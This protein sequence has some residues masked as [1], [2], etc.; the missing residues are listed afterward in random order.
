MTERQAAARPDLSGNLRGMA[1]MFL[2]TMLFA[3]MHACVRQV[4]QD[5]DPLIVA[6]FRNFFG[7]AVILPI[8]LRTGMAPLKTKRLGLLI[9][10]AAI[11]VVAM[12]TFF[13]ALSMTPLADVAAL[14]FT[15][16][17][18]ATL[19][20]M[21]VLGE[22]VHLRRWTAILL[23]F[24]GTFVI[25]RPGF[26]TVSMGELLVLISALAW[27]IA[28]IIIKVLGRTESALMITIYMVLLMA[29]LSLVPAAFV[30][31]WPV[32]LEWLWLIAIGALG[33]FA[34]LTMTQS[35][36]EGETQVVMPLDFFKLIWAAL[37]GYFAFAEV[38]DIFVWL[39]GVMIFASAFYIA[40]RESQLNRQAVKDLA[41][42]T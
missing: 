34:Q 27:S 29:P 14:G 21:I 24:A 6:F 36:K 1:W 8:L 5:L 9:L 42:P 13:Y 11:N 2:A 38:P 16:P 28:L 39:G 30:W 17:V 35:L 22:R 37:I 20:A 10:R 31:R 3:S 4:T 23:G 25:L 12:L 7:L 40:T 18:F 26:E 15:A 33:S 41:G 19:L 32:G